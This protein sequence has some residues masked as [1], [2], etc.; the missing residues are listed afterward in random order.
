M[1]AG[2]DLLQYALFIS[3]LFEK[4]PIDHVSV[5]VSAFQRSSI[6]VDYYSFFHFSLHI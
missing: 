5:F 4:Y 3:E 2:A 1:Q 6:R